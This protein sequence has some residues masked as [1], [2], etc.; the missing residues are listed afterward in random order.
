MNFNRDSSI[1]RKIRIIFAVLA[2]P[3]IVILFIY[4]VISMNEVKDR[5]ANT[6]CASVGTFTSTLRNQM[7]FA[8]NYMV[9]MALRNENVRRLGEETNHTQAYLDCY[10]AGNE[11]AVLLKANDLLT[12]YMIYSVFNDML[13]VNYNN[14]GTENPI[15]QLQIKQQIQEEMMSLMRSGPIDTERWFV[16]GIKG[17]IYWIRI[18]KYRS[19]YQACLIDIEQL[20]THNAETYNLYGTMQ[21]YD[22]EG[23]PLWEQMKIPLDKIDWVQDNYGT[24]RMNRKDYIVVREKTDT[25]SL[26]YLS[27]YGNIAGIMTPISMVLL[28]CSVIIILAIPV[29]WKYLYHTVLR[30]LDVLVSTMEKIGQGELTA[31]PSTDYNSREFKQV[32]DTFNVMINQITNLKIAHYEQE[33]EAERS[34]MAA[35]K[36]QIHP[37]F[38]LNC[39]KNVYAL[40]QTG[41]YQEI[42]TLTLLLSRHLRSILVISEDSVELEKELELCQNYIELQNIGQNLSSRCSIKADERLKKLLV[43]QVS[44]LTIVENCV[45]HAKKEDKALSVSISVK[46]LKM[47]QNNLVNIVVTDNGLGFSEKKLHELNYA[48]SKEKDGHHVGL[49]N[50]LR[51]LQLLYGKDVEMV[52]SNVRTGGA[53]VE[54]Y[55]PVNK[56]KNYGMEDACEIINRG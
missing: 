48:E 22:A 17:K 19:V 4:A 37:H 27:E 31:R 2:L 51:R 40:A 52:F 28:L 15:K 47:E 18:V 7:D 50:V 55:I 38:I 41:R 20:L 12:G 56:R 39:L 21:L 30:P 9:D 32:N 45:K 26:F 16:K 10:E 14:V 5:M 8:E 23:T 42:Q 36:M 11:A 53:R 44:I 6:M 35:L 46:L 13:S 24:V 1:K 34:E 54:L 33:L 43:P 29:I 25:Q 49:A 3:T